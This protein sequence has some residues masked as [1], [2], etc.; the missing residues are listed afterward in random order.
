NEVLDLYHVRPSPNSPPELQPA[1]PFVHA[2]SI[3]NP[4]GEIVRVK[5]LFDDGAMVNVMCID[6]WQRV[7]HRVGKLQPSGRRLRM[8]N[9]TIEPSAGYWLGD[10]ELGGVRV[11]SA[12]EVLP[13]GG[14]W[15]FLAGK[16]ILEALRAVHDYGPD[17]LR[18]P[19]P[20]GEVVLRN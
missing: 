6:L 4:S 7:Q 12:F 16:P 11:R 20:S 17:T 14:A 15:S 1:K 3:H 10:I 5:A 18:V 13:S 2:I 19:A 9:G 8:A